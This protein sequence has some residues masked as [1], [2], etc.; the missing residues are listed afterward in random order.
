MYLILLCHF[1]IH[2]DWGLTSAPGLKEAFAWLLVQSGQVGVVIFFAITGYFMVNSTFKISQLVK[3]WIQIF[4]Y[5]AGIL[6]ACLAME[7]I[8]HASNSLHALFTGFNLFTT[9]RRTLLPVA[10]GEYW[11]L[12]AYFCLLLLIPFLNKLLQTMPIKYIQAL[13]I[14][15]ILLGC[16]PLLGAA[17]IFFDSIM[18]AIMCYLIGGYLRIYP[19]TL[20]RFTPVKVFV[21]SVSGIIISLVFN[22]LTQLD[23]SIIRYLQ[24]NTQTKTGVRFIQIIIGI[25]ILGATLAQSRKEGP[26]HNAAINLFASSTFGIY[27]IHE[28]Y[29]GYRLLWGAINRV[30]PK[31]EG[32]IMEAGGDC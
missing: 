25:S 9:L 19:E 6:F 12:T 13:I 16:M 31:P 2:I 1:T 22:Y 27:L 28:H 24:W 32:V 20:N 21:I 17:P 7:L 10:S 26:M 11:F 15:L 30:I 23:S 5:S 29:L 14:G 8:T 4:I 18:Y 3:T